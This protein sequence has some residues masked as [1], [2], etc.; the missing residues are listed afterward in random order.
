MQ[1]TQ[2]SPRVFWITFLVIS[3][4]VSGLAFY[5]A[6]PQLIS[7]GIDPWRSKWTI[8]LL[9]FSVNIFIG[10]FVTWGLVHGY[11]KDWLTRFET[12]S[13]PRWMRVVSAVIVPSTLAVFCFTRFKILGAIL[14]QFFPTL[15]I[16][17][18]LSLIS[19]LALKIA[20][21]AALTES[22]VATLLVQGLL[23]RIWGIL[24]GVTDF[25]FTIEYSETS[26]YYYGSLIFSKSLYG[27]DLP[28]S[29]LHPSRYLL[30]AIPFIIPGLP[31]WAHRLWQA[32]LWIVLTGLSAWLLARRM[33]F[34]GKSITALV[35]AWGF[36]YFLQGVVYYHLQVCVI[37]ILLG[38][39]SKYTWRTLL[40]VILASFWAG[41]SRVN[42]FPVPAML[43]IALYLLNEP[44][45]TSKG[46]W[47]YLKHPVLWAV[48]GISAA[49]LSQV[50]YVFWSGNS[51]NVSDFSSSFTSDLIWSRLLPN[52]TYALGVF[53]SI[54]IVSTPLLMVLLYAIYGHRMNWHFI[55]PLGIFSMLGI[56]FIGGLVVSTKIGGGADIH[57]MDAFMVLLAIVAVGFL[58][59]QVM[60]E[61]AD[62]LWGRIP[63]W[64]LVLAAFIPTVFSLQNVQLRF[65]YDRIQAQK[66][67][68]ALQKVI[69]DV[70]D[71]G[72]EVLFIS[73][74]HLLIFHMVPDV[75]LVPDYE[76]ITL[77][78]MAMSGNQVYLDQFYKD[79]A[80]HRFMAIITR[81][82]RV[83]KK[84]DEPF[85]E[86]N[87]VWIDAISRPLLCYYQRDLTL[88]SSNTL[89]LV[90]AQAGGSCP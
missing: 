80:S 88:E 12:A 26:R 23:F 60:P 72:G 76:V 22:F 36:I 70:H 63:V 56:L 84:A 59:G 40:V 35:A 62:S 54:L 28:L 16:F 32:L 17:L 78:E 87:N 30:Q 38:F 5:Q 66:D 86:E 57:N 43:A 2:N 44:F 75:E 1:R 25:P 19:A 11:Y 9:A 4:P 34:P 61:K 77:M 67:L 46:L 45:S 20:S 50:L 64:V 51:N 85:S 6:L 3:M 14:P 69:A 52:V 48:T 68:T 49:F 33:R 10:G 39:S 73:D 71:Q 83:V 58:A 24:N 21:G 53:P 37:I 42:W 8:A 13:F 29:T 27:L 65:A 41:I 47:Q 89:V 74:R 79:L 7:E 55:R 18:W 81:T 15:W 31:L 90:P 82:Q